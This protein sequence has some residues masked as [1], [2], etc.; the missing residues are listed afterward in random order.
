MTSCYSLET[1]VISLFYKMVVRDTVFFVELLVNYSASV[2]FLTIIALV[3]L[4]PQ[5]MKEN[6]SFKGLVISLAYT[7]YIKCPVNA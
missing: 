3:L 7:R 6:T 1:L 5:F 2:V 4:E